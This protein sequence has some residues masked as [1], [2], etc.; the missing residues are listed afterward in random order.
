MTSWI[1][2]ANPVQFDVDGFLASAP[3]K[4]LWLAKQHVSDLRIGDQVFFWRAIG[5]GEK[6]LSGIVAEGIISA[7]PAA[8]PDRAESVPYWL[9]G[10]GTIPQMRV[11]VDLQR[12]ELKDRFKR[13][14]LDNDP[15][16]S[17]SAILKLR[18]GTRP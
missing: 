16:M 2:Q 13:S 1:F 11:E 6:A 10:D 3:P 7:P 14:W 8:V 4:L 17:N 15:I 18:T 9:S 12:I 5:G